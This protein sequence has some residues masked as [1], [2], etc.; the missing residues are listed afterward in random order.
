M[1]PSPT[2]QLYAWLIAVVPFL[3]MSILLGVGLA[4]LL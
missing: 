1:E 3:M 2:E 4:S